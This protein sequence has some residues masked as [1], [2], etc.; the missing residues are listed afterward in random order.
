MPPCATAVVYC[1][2][3]RLRR[4]LLIAPL[5]CEEHCC[6]FPRLMVLVAEP[7]KVPIETMLAALLSFGFFVLICD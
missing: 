4:K 6:F 2:C 7:G 1:F 5:C 3:W